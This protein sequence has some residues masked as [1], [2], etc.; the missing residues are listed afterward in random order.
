MSTITISKWPALTIATFATAIF[1]GILFGFAAAGWPTIGVGDDKK[2]EHIH[3]NCYQ[4][5]ED[6]PDCLC[7][8]P[9]GEKPGDV[10]F[11]QPVNTV[12]N[13]GFVIVGLS[14]AYVSDTR[15]FPSPDWWTSRN[16]LM[17]QTKLYPTVYSTLV[18]IMG[19]GSAFL[20]ASFLKWGQQIDILCMMNIGTFLV[21]YGLVRNLDLT[22]ITAVLL[23]SSIMTGLTLWT[24][25]FTPSVLQ[26]RTAFASLLLAA[27][28]LEGIIRLQQYWKKWIKKEAPTSATDLRL[29]LG[30][31]GTAGLAIIIWIPS[32]TGGPLCDPDSLFQG[33]AVWHVL[34]AIAL[35]FLFLYA[36]SE[37]QCFEKVS[38]PLDASTETEEFHKVDLVTGDEE[39]GL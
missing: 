16:N 39:N 12:S 9:R 25:L 13:I 29:L 17:T 21:I 18:S 31:I 22:Q 5:F 32:K 11:A 34:C 30:A 19:P 14:I 7:E 3:Q 26:S 20:H 24:V 8:R 23:Q 33:H 36:L 27:G 2:G 37:R 28:V 4:D 35:G 10:W 6:N 15:R 38:P 1:T